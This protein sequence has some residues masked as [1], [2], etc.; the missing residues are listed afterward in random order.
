MISG[1]LEDEKFTYEFNCD[2]REVQ[3]FRDEVAEKASKITHMDYVSVYGPLCKGNL[4]PGQVRNN[5][6][7]SA[8][9]DKHGRPRYNFVY[10]KYEYPYLVTLINGFLDGDVDCLYDIIHPNFEK[11]YIPEYDKIKEEIRDLR[12]TD[13]K[14][15]NALIEKT[16]KLRDTLIEVKSGNIFIP[17]AKYY[18]EFLNLINLQVKEKEN[19]QLTKK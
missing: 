2:K 5:H 12:R 9:R 11:E 4:K 19:L 14:D 7:Y 8:G 10:D 13:V 15:V 3:Y 17:A 6:V 16:N 18:N 1:V